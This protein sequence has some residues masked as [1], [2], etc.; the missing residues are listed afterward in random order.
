MDY[1]GSII[2]VV[3]FYEKLNVIGTF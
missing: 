2:Q 3:I 1:D